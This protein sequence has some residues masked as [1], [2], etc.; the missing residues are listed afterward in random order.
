MMILQLKKKNLF[1]V[2]WRSKLTGFKG[3]GQPIN[4]SAAYANA[5]Y[6]NK[7]HPDILHWVESA[8]QT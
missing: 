6:A 4:E 1:Q 2:H 8:N 3:C 7:E 5:S